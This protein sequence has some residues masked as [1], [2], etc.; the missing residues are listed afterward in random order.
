M[1]ANNNSNNNNSNNNENGF[2]QGS[3]NPRRV[4]AGAAGRG[5]NV[6]QIT[7]EQFARLLGEGLQPDLALVPF[8]MPRIEPPPAREA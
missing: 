3:D 4:G 5:R 1:P 7:T 2:M 8:Q 6:T